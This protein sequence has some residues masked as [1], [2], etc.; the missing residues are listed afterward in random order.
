MYDVMH[1]CVCVC[2]LRC[3]NNETLWKLHFFLYKRWSWFIFNIFPSFL[4]KNLS[5]KYFR[6]QIDFYM[7][8]FYKENNFFLVNIRFH[9]SISFPK[10]NY[11]LEFRNCEKKRLGHFVYYNFIIRMCLDSRLFYICIQIKKYNLTYV[12]WSVKLKPMTFF[13]EVL[14]DSF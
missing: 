1:V 9:K 8:N 3:I 12:F 10:R 6:L 14:T 13:L 2:L 7:K 5:S 4:S 11:G